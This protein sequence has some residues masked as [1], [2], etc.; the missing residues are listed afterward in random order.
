[1]KDKVK[2]PVLTVSRSDRRRLVDQMADGIR[3]EIVSGA[4]RAGDML[5]RFAELAKRFNVSLRIPREA[6]ARLAAEGYVDTRAG[7]GTTVLPKR[8]PTWK[9]HVVFVLPDAVGS[10][11][12]NVFAGELQDRLTREGWL[13]TRV[14]VLKRT[15]GR[16]DT[17]VL[18][19]ELAQSV[20]L[21]IMPYGD[22]LVEKL[23]TRKKVPY[24]VLAGRRP[25]EPEAPCFVCFNRL[26]AMDDFVRHCREAGVG[27]VVQVC[28]KGEGDVDAVPA[29]AAAGIEARREVVAFKESQFRLEAIERAAFRLVYDKVAERARSEGELVFFTDDFLAFGGITALLAR[30][31]RV[32]DEVKV[33]AWANRGFVPVAPWSVTRMEVDPRA[34]AQTVA[35]L[36][37][38]RLNGDEIPSDATIGPK[39]VKGESFA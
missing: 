14:G 23:L 11:Y 16:R 30:G 13:F 26:A 21:A 33:V 4:L 10:Y 27:K 28:M 22:V 34:N 5:P 6:I 36:V 17:S 31:V 37:L 24:L 20:D 18:Q 29:L 2:I 35:G 12:A 7:V 39:Y 1:M 19:A 15:N 9:G 25:T 8:V 38:G 32:P 3:Q